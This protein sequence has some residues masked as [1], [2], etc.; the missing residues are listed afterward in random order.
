[1]DQ[2]RGVIQDVGD[3]RSSPNP[4]LRTYEAINGVVERD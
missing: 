2:T 3:G 4:W 1:M